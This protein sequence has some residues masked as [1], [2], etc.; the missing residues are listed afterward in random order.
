VVEAKP[1]VKRAVVQDVSDDEFSDT[2][3]GSGS[4]SGSGSDS[5]ESED[6]EGEVVEA[7][8]EVA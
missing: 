7:Q 4:G 6:D 8:A 2:S 1:V 5:G 3:D